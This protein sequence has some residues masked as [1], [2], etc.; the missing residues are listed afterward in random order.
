MTEGYEVP[1][2]EVEAEIVLVGETPRPIRLFLAERA[3][4]HSG[5]ERPSDLLN[6]ADEP[7]LPVREP[8]AGLV[9]VHRAAVL[10]LTVPATVEEGP[11][12][13]PEGSGP[14]GTVDGEIHVRLEGG[15]ELS[16]VV[17]E[18]MPEG[19]RRVQDYLNRAGPFV[20]LRDGASI[21][22]VN[23]SRIVRVKLL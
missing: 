11:E 14:G 9:L 3:R 4:H 20:P 5:P 21:R 1:K 19:E 17:R 15:A 10:V 8:E 18:P 6:A 22:F 13:E 2:R 16:G 23:R 7:F 12:P